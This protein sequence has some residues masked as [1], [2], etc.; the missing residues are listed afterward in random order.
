V[1]HDS[2]GG[3]QYRRFVSIGAQVLNQKP[4]LANC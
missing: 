3:E 2:A 1:W 4:E